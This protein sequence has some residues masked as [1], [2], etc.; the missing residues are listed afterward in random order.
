MGRDPL[1]ESR[2]TEADFTKGI[3]LNDNPDWE[4]WWLLYCY[5]AGITNM[6]TI[7]CKYYYYYFGILQYNFTILIQI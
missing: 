3:W 6:N 4:S 5:L 7:F 1:A 2:K